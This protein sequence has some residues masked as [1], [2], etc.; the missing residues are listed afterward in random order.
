MKYNRFNSRNKDYTSICPSTCQLALWRHE[1]TCTDLQALT[2]HSV[3]NIRHTISHK[4]INSVLTKSVA[5]AAKADHTASGIAAE[6]NRQKCCIW[7]SHVTWSH[8]P[9][10][11]QMWKFRRHHFSLCIVAEWNMLQQWWLNDASYGKNVN[12]KCPHRNTT[13]QLST[14]YTDSEHHNLLHD[15]QTVWCQQ[16]ILFV[17]Q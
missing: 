13:V 4:L 3:L 2:V 15:R 11:F 8:C 6:L 14:P 16:L 10:L 7:K 9:W 1:C 5:T 12:R 17:Q